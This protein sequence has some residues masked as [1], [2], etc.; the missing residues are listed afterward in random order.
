MDWNKIGEIALSVIVAFGGAGAIAIGAVKWISKILADRLSRKYQLQLDEK[1]ET[2][3]TALNKKEYI[4]K[5]RFDAEFRM[6]QELSEKNIAMVYCAGEAVVIVRGA[7]YSSQEIE[8]FVAKFCDE[9]NDAEMTNRRYAPFIEE[10]IYERYLMLE[11][12]ATEIFLLIKAWKQFNASD[13]F[14]IEISDRTYQSSLE[15]K[16]AIE[17]KQ[18]VL[19]DESNALLKELRQHLNSLDVLDD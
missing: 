19:S 2:V 6:Y 15:L 13:D 7:P 10:R 11:K 4:S 5:T 18:K 1:L 8:S 3:K 14:K 17:E 16:K 9:L 12:K